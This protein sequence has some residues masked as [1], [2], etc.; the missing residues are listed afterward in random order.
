MGG[1]F[2]SLECKLRKGF[3]KSIIIGAAECVCHPDFPPFIPF[4]ENRAQAP[5]TVF[6][7]PPP[8]FSIFPSRNSPAT[9][10]HRVS[11]DI[12]MKKL[13]YLPPNNGVLINQLLR[14]AFPNFRIDED[15]PRLAFSQVVEY[16]GLLNPLFLNLAL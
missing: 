4:W 9:S 2:P 6:I 15:S 11:L 7:P 8:V 14:L 1:H 12:R 13:L 10:S 16:A 5:L 3:L